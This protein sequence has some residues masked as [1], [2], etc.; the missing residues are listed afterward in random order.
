MIIDAF[1]TAL[2]WLWNGKPKVKREG[3]CGG[4]RGLRRP[5]KSTSGPFYVVAKDMYERTFRLSSKLPDD[6]VTVTG[7]KG[8]FRR[9]IQTI[10]FG[11]SLRNRGPVST[12][13][14]TCFSGRIEL[15]G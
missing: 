15:E 11:D 13:S 2:N 6:F 9:I 10:D 5:V 14:M 3:V 12:K 4:I 7:D 1:L 8:F